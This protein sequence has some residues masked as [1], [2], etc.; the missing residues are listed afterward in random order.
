MSC[1]ACLKLQIKGLEEIVV[2]VKYCKSE[3]WS[4]AWDRIRWHIRLSLTLTKWVSN[5]NVTQHGAHDTNAADPLSWTLY[6]HPDL[7]SMTSVWCEP[8]WLTHIYKQQAALFT[9]LHKYIHNGADQDWMIAGR[10]WNSGD[11]RGGDGRKG[12]IGTIFI[13]FYFQNMTRICCWWK[14]NISKTSR[15]HLCF[16]QHTLSGHF[17]RYTCTIQCCSALA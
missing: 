14:A 13:N 9:Y 3:H 16:L 17:I 8:T 12:D 6:V 7:L 15:Q 11:P 1:S 2:L 5:L 4:E 10:H